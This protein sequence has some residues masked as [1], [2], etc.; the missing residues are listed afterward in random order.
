MH[1]S[2]PSPA[3]PC[4]VAAG[5]SAGGPGSPEDPRRIRGAGS[6]GEA[7]ARGAARCVPGGGASG[8]SRLV[9]PRRRG[10]ERNRPFAALT[11]RG[12]DLF[13][14]RGQP[15]RLRRH[16]PVLCPLKN[17]LPARGRPV[18]LPPYY[19]CVPSGSG[20]PNDHTPR[21]A[22][23]AAARSEPL[24][25]LLEAGKRGCWRLS[26]GPERRCLFWLWRVWAR[27][28]WGPL[29]LPVVPTAGSDGNRSGA[30]EMAWPG[31][32]A[33]SSSAAPW[34][35]CVTTSLTRATSRSTTCVWCGRRR[36]PRG[37]WGR[38][39]SSARLWRPWGVRLRC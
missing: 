25:G 38:E 32:K 16:S 34:M 9:Q 2:R 15:S 35:W 26:R 14:G 24:V 29:P 37:P 1:D 27:W 21:S 12:Q 19:A 31:L 11:P 18:A 6:A 36:S 33:R 4:A 22:R 39:P 10:R 30:Q 28:A 23:A 7:H 3:G 13:P 20:Q 8:V 5:R 17:I